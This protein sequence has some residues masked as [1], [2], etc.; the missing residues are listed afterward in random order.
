MSLHHDQRIQALVAPAH[1]SAIAPYQA[2][3][4]I[5]EL[6]REFGLDPA[7]IVKLASN[8]NPLGMPKSARAAMLAAAESL[9]R[10]P[11]PN[12]F[13]LKSALATRYGVPMN[14]ITL[15]NGSN[16]ILEIVALALLEPGTSAVYAQ[17]SFAVY[18]LATQARARAHRCRPRTTAMTWTRCSTPLPTTPAWSSSPT[19]TSHRHLVPGEQVA[20]FLERVQAAHGDRVTVVLDEAYNEYLDPEFR[21]DSTALARRYPNLIVS[22]TFS[23]AYGLAGLRVGFAVSQPALTDLLNR[24]RQPFNVNTLAQAAAIAALADSAYLEEAYAT[25]KAG[26]AQLCQAFDALAALRAQ[27]RQLR[28]GA[29][30]RRAPHQS[31][32]AQAWRDRASGGRRRPAGMAARVHRTAAGKRPLHRGAERDPGRMNGVSASADQGPLAPD[33]V[34]AVAG[35]GL[36]GVRSPPRCAAPARSA[37]CWGRAQRSPLARALELGLID[38]A[39]SAEVAAARADMILLA[40]PVGGLRDLLIRM[41]PTLAPRAILTDAGST[42]AEVVDGRAPPWAGV[43]RSSC[44]AIP[45]PARNAPGPRRPT[46]ACIAGATWC[47]RR[48][49]RTRRRTWRV[50]AARLRRDGGRHGS[51]GA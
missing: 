32:I 5:E 25:N 6:A 27:L 50:R 38:E 8:E 39:V 42:K 49:P 35:V 4:P 36:I 19:R 34:L 46:P 29:C 40:T 21:F 45:S 9:A 26:K 24:V 2:G 7:G 10:Y 33:S 28:A 13:D 12:G 47:S 20:A 41:L 1:V 15:G 37:R 48:C 43:A 18:R 23:K 31:G 44:P 17:H 16:D 11:D 14:W 22:R 30:G 51:A 3:K